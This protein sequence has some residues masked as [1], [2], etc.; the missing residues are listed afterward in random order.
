M[1][2]LRFL[3]LSALVL[4]CNGTLEAQSMYADAHKLVAASKVLDAH[5]YQLNDSSALEAYAQV[6]A[7][8]YE[9][10][11][12]DM[13]GETPSYTR[14]NRLPHRY[15]ENPRLSR[16]LVFDSLATSIDFNYVH[17][18]PFLTMYLDTL[19][20]SDRKQMMR[21][22]HG[23]HG[24]SP[25]EYLSVSR[26]LQRHSIPPMESLQNLQV[27]AK[28]TNQ[29]VQG[30]IVNTQELLEGV[31]NFVLKRAQEEIVIN[32]MERFL[33]NDLAEYEEI[34]PTVFGQFNL[35]GFTYSQSFLERLRDAFYRDVQML[36]VRLPIILLEDGRFTKIQEDPLVFNL[37][38]VYSMIG[39]VQAGTPLTEIIPLTH[40]NLH[41][42][43]QEAQKKANFGIAS[44]P[45]SDASYQALVAQSRKVLD[46][47][48]HIYLALN[49]G[50]NKMLAD[51]QQQ[52][53]ATPDFAALFKPEYRLDAIMGSDTAEGFRLNLLPSLLAGHLDTAY[54]LGF[55]SV[56]AY[57][58]FFGVSRTPEQWR[59]AGIELARNLNGTW[60]NDQSIAQILRNWTSDLSA[61]QLEYDRW[62]RSLKDDTELMELAFSELENSK[63][64]LVA[65]IEA[66]KSFWSP[67]LSGNQGIRFDMLKAI[68]NESY[69]MNDIQVMIE[70]TAI[71]EEVALSQ[72]LAKLQHVEDRLQTLNNELAETHADKQTGNPIHAYLAEKRPIRPFAQTF[73]QIDALAA[74]LFLLEKQ[75]DSLEATYAEQA[76]KRMENARPLLQIT[77][78]MSHFMYCL[79]SSDP[80]QVW[81][82]KAELDTLLRTPDLRD[83]FLG[84]LYQRMSRVEGTTKFSPEALANLVQLTVGDL[85]LLLQPE[86]LPSGENMG[87]YDAA[88]F[89]VNT[90][91]RVLEIPL[92]VD[93]ANPNTLKS[94]MQID[95]IRLADIPKV[96]SEVLNLLHNLNLGDHRRAMS[97][98]IRL[99]ATVENFDADESVHDFLKQ[100]GYFIADLIDA[101]TTEQVESLL[102][103]IADP[104]G[105]SRL[106]RSKRLTVGL[107]AYLGASSGL[108]SWE[109]DRINQ[110]EEF[111]FVAPTIPIGITMSRLFGNGDNP[112]SLSLFI[113]FLDLGSMLTLRGSSEFFGESK[114]TF[115]NMFKPSAQ[116]HWNLPKSPFY[117]GAGAQ[118]GPHYQDVGG[119]EQAVQSTRFFVSFGVDVP[120]KTFFAR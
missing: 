52:S 21:L 82:S 48:K 22:L 84:L 81:M 6:L 61:Y 53:D 29:N 77:E 30:G 101:T 89:L 116:L 94:F 72:G 43:Y 45:L 34:F 7:I 27:L 32:F 9:Y 107:N 28:K 118:I 5:D 114:L 78:M 97:A 23:E 106:K 58:K 76:F 91:N 99:F 69:D 1:I 119:I 64:E 25:A 38:T 115:K 110:Q 59:A 41:D 60:Y 66:T 65:V 63:Q 47:I 51:I 103:G 44:A 13:I 88:S 70:I 105:S 68:L 35:G 90:L 79:R 40:R 26:A 108:E 117:L 104:P 15:H 11:S 86:T 100:Y 62:K 17:Y 74:D 93:P 18:S 83:A 111:L 95:S 3:V 71:G 102:Y 85:P 39:M 56:P 16:L 42:N 14:L 54:L 10:D 92:V 2:R 73:A 120:V 12:P 80:E 75:I 49:Q 109:N 87:L 20:H 55:R 112:P 96:S 19:D 33:N 113:G 24:A 37:L 31:F 67:S 57:D 98:A 46:R 50:E 36:G 8:L 4:L